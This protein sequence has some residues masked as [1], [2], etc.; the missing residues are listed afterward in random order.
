MS[1]SEVDERPSEQRIREAQALDGIEYFVVS[2]PK[3]LTMYSAAA[4]TVGGVQFE[5]VDLTALVQRALD[6]AAVRSRYPRPGPR[7][8]HV[9]GCG[10]RVL[11]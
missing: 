1:E 8:P 9:A 11:A 10:S 4:Q 3:D 5:V 2:C 7:G 6:P